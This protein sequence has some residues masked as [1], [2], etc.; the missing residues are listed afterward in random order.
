MHKQCTSNR[1]HLQVEFTSA[2]YKLRRSAFQVFLQVFCCLTVDLTVKYEIQ[3]VAFRHSQTIISLA[4][5]SLFVCSSLSIYC[6]GVQP[7]TQ[8]NTTIYSTAKSCSRPILSQ[9]NTDEIT[10]SYGRNTAK[11]SL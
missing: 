10:T 5:E 3:T 7:S 4:S 9:L 6:T 2:F 11:I 1:S 8:Q